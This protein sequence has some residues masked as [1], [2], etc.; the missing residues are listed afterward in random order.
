MVSDENIAKQIAERY[1]GGYWKVN[2]KFFFDKAKCLRYATSIKNLDITFHYH[3]EFYSSLSWD[4]PKESL[5]ELYKLRAQQL[6]DKYDY[7]ILSFSGGA[8]SYNVLDTFL[9]NN[10]FI[11]CVATSYPIKAIEKLKHTFNP[12][13]RSADNVIFE[14]TEVAHPKLLEVARLSPKTEIAVLDHTN[15][16]IDLLLDGKLHIMPVGGI[17]AAP[18]LAGH[19]LIGQ[20]VREYSQKGKAVYLTGVDK[21]KLGYNTK[22]KKFGTYFEDI[23]LVLGNYTEEAF[24]GYHPLVEHFYYS[25]EMTQILQKQLAILRRSLSPVINTPFNDLPNNIKKTIQVTKTGNYRFQVHDIFFKELLYS[26]WNNNFF[27]A[28]KPSGFFFQEHSNWYL[29]GDL[30]DKRDKD[31]H[32]GQVMEFLHGIDPRLIYHS[33]EGAP[34]KFVEFITKPISLS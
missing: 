26:N 22:I 18:G 6:R 21:P 23:S 17:G 32:Y 12:L 11:D 1:S 9:K 14:Y 19:Y 16:A 20:K 5:D 33:K 25:T 30:T 4:E 24:S 13:D 27:Q 28:G 34:L 8:D 31:Y 3:D 29:K 10:I 7:I 2:G 15:T